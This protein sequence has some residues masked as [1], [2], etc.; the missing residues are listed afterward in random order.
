MKTIAALSL[1]LASA[2]AFAPTTTRNSAV[3]SVA[4]LNAAVDDAFGISIETGNKCP[5]L[6]KLI[7]QDAGPEGVKWFQNAELK[8]GRVAMVATIGFWVQKLGVHFPLYLGP[9]GSNGFHPESA[10]NWLLSSTTGTTF[11]DIA[12]AAPLDA[13]NMVPAQGWFQIFLVAGWFE[14][15]AY[16][17][18]WAQEGS[19]EMIPGDY[20]YDPLGFTKKEGGIAGK[21]FESLRMKEIKNGRVAMMTIAA[22]VS[23]EAIPGAL[24]TWHP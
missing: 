5:P 15:I 24:P 11:A 7:L 23:N 9:S 2:S 4:P 1:C 14:C 22:W 19:G 13:I 17:R 18:Q 12:Q 10:D 20:G 8:H 3:R 16:D 6:G 21:D